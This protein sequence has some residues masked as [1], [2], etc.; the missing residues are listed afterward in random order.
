[1]NIKINKGLILENF[2]TDIIARK[3][4]GVVAGKTNDFLMK[5]VDENYPPEAVAEFGKEV[6]KAGLYNDN[7]SFN[8]TFKNLSKK[9]NDPH[10]LDRIRKLTNETIL[11]N[12]ETDPELAAK[13]GKDATDFKLYDPDMQTTNDVLRHNLGHTTDQLSHA[14]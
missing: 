14:F 3:A 6:T 4:K 13:M 5:R 10:E 12:S 8:D 11:K 1:M 2:F 7:V 9:S